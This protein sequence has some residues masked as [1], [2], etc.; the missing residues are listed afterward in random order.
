LH[1]EREEEN[2]PAA[3]E[4]HVEAAVAPL[5]VNT[6]AE[7][8]N[9]TAEAA[10]PSVSTAAKPALASAMLVRNQA[11]VSIIARGTIALIAAEL[12][13]CR[14]LR[15]SASASIVAEVEGARTVLLRPTPHHDVKS[16]CKR[17]GMQPAHG[18]LLL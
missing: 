11:S 18:A 1:E 4:A 3:E 10:D 2:S 15:P 12:R 6:A 13:L 16:R 14:H 5:S 7:E 17:R 8:A 9:A